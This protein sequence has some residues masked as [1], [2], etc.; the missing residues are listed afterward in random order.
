MKKSN[1]PVEQTPVHNLKQC[2]EDK[3]K[4]EIIA[5]WSRYPDAKFQAGAISCALDRKRFRVKRALVEMAN[6]GLVDTWDSDGTPFYS[7]THTEKV[8][9]LVTETESITWSQLQFILRNVE[10]SIESAAIVPSPVI[11]LTDYSLIHGTAYI[12]APRQTI[13]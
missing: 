13:N 5:F 11:S 4:T 3:L 9:H 1:S 8:R 2:E 6:T 7:L 12:S 10:Q